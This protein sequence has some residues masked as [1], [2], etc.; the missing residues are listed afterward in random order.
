MEEWR[1]GWVKATFP[2][3]V[4]SRETPQHLCPHEYQET[5]YREAG[6]QHAAKLPGLPALMCSMSQACF[7]WGVVRIA[8]RKLGWNCLGPNSEISLFSSLLTFS[9]HFREADSY[10]G[11]FSRPRKWPG[12][13]WRSPAL[14]NKSKS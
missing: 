10:S 11:V 5:E 3:F 1:V 9:S 14:G 13:Q 7:L 4:A 8:R 2:P 6:R 12:F